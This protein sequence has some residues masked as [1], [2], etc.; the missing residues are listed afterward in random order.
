MHEVRE[1]LS[2]LGTPEAHIAAEALASRGA[3]GAEAFL[4]ALDHGSRLG[5]DGAN[6]RAVMEDLERVLIDVGRAHPHVFL[7][8]AERSESLVTRFAFVS[9]LT[10]IPGEAAADRLVPLLAARDGSIRWLALEA[11][12]TRSDPRA[13][14]H[15]P[16]ALRDRDGLVVFT[17]V[18]AM[19]LW[20]GADHVANLEAIARAKKTSIGTREAAFDAIEGICRRVGCAAP[21]GVPAPRLVYVPLPDGAT[22]EVSDA[23]LVSRGAVLARTSGDSIFAPC[24]AQVVDIEVGAIV[25]RRRSND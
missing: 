8:W 11:L 15:L 13:I 24:D 16:R 1:L 7:E 10:S 3:D 25:L 14:A 9:A 6:G 19:R 22:L 12:L 18:R 4:R 21:A 17:A 20:G 2:R 5:P 23:T